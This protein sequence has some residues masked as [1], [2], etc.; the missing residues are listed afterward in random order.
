V[1]PWNKQSHLAI[2]N[3]LFVSIFLFPRKQ[4]LEEVSCALWMI[5]L[6]PG[7][8]QVSALPTLWASLF[9]PLADSVLGVQ[10]QARLCLGSTLGVRQESP[11]G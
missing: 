5:L 11:P 9:L 10:C 6:G 7:W 4:G 2:Q 1:K 3:S 8:W